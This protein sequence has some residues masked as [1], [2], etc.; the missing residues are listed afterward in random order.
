MYRTFK[1]DNNKALQKRTGTDGY[2][3]KFLVEGARYFVKVQC[4]LSGEY[5]DDWR[6]EDIASRTGGQLDLGVLKQTPCNVQISYTKYKRT[7]KGVYSNN[8]ELLGYRYRSFESII[9]SLGLETKRNTNFIKMSN[10]DK[11]KWMATII[12][13]HTSI[14][15][16]QYLDYL[17]RTALIDI[18]VGNADRHTRNIGLLYNINKQCEEVSPIFDCG[19]GLFEHD[20]WI[21]H[22]A[23]FDEACGQLYIE[24]YSED[25]IILLNELES[26]FGVKQKLKAKV[27]KLE[28]SK[29]LFPSDNAYRYFKT[30]LK[31]FR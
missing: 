17:I 9:N 11:I 12:S 15:Y 22:N 5:V 8:F 4:K 14:S 20:L 21:K 10:I 24:P 13:N 28:I 1:V 27:N 23:S 30:I 25:P 3:P 29:S 2:Q 16:N 26:E 7:L 6:V 31:E 19:M 18:I